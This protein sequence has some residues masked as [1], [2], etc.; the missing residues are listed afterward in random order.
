MEETKTEG[1]LSTAASPL[2]LTLA[3]NQ[4]PEPAPESLLGIVGPAALSLPA[5]VGLKKTLNTSKLRF[6]RSL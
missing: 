2:V 6:L 5:R 1:T 4:W 3:V